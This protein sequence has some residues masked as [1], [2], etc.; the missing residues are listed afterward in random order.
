VVRNVAL[1]AA[2]TAAWLVTL[3]IARFGPG[4]WGDQPALAWLAIGVNVAVGVGWMVAHA[5][6]LG[7][8]DELQRKI[9]L[10]AIAVALGVGLVGGFA[11][12]AAEASGLIVLESGIGLLAT[13]M[14]VVYA[15]ASIGGTARY[16]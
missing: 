9:M 1:L 7:S 3:A 4:L 13:L 2:W 6:Y 8:L 5:R 11:L 12:A 10:E 15:V 14:G 16:R